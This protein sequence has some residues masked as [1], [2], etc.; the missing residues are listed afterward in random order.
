MTNPSPNHPHIQRQFER[1]PSA[2]SYAVSKKIAGQNRNSQPQ[3][4]TQTSAIA[5]RQ[6]CL[7]R[8]NPQPFRHFPILWRKRFHYQSQRLQIIQHPV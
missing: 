7:P 4:Q 1:C 8:L 5:Q 3:T 6:S 2:F